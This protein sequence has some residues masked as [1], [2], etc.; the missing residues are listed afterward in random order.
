M[1]DPNNQNPMNPTQQPMQQQPMQQPMQPMQQPVPGVPGPG[2]PMTAPAGPPQL[3]I[4]SDEA[5][6]LASYK[7]AKTSLGG[8]AGVKQYAKFLGPQG[9][10]RWDGVHVG[11]EGSILARILPAWAPGK[12][13]FAEIRSHFYKSTQHPKGTSIGC[14]GEG[15]L[16]CAARQAGLDH[17]DPA[18]QEHAKNYGRVRKQYAYNILQLDHPEAHMCEDGVMRP[19]ILQ[20]SATLHVAIGVIINDQGLASLLDPMTGR[21]VVLKKIKTGREER[22]VDYAAIHRDSEPIPQVFWPAL[23]NLHDLEREQF[24]PTV[25]D[26]MTAVQAMR[27]PMPQQ[28][29]AAFNPAPAPAYPNPYPQPMQQPVQQPMQQPMMPQV[30]APPPPPVQ[31]TPQPQMQYPA[32]GAAPQ[33]VQTPAPMQQPMP[34]QQPV[35]QPVQQ[36]A[37][38]GGM[39]LTKPLAPGVQLEGGRERCFGNYN[40]SDRWCL[41]CPEW[42]RTQCVPQSGQVTGLDQLQHQLA[43][44]SQ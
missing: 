43:G 24:N 9:Q 17:P 33:P 4:P 11:Y 14:V 38:Q 26:Q 22:D 16:I 39:Q 3:Y 31:S 15:C 25:A 18:M 44:T 7:Q 20:A 1:N 35:Q 36:P 34:Q 13:F 42:I 40:Q 29:P 28:Q 2:G 19:F 41:E 30:E 5:A 37:S 21:P 32:Q 8:G 27:L 12:S 10:T 23:E 6:I